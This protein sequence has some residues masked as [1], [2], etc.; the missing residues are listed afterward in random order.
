MATAELSAVK[1]GFGYCLYVPKR[2][3]PA[4]SG[5]SVFE[6]QVTSVAGHPRT[7]SLFASHEQQAGRAYLDLFCLDADHG[8][9]FLVGPI[10]ELDYKGF[11]DAYNRQG[12]VA[13]KDTEM[14]W[15]ERRLSIWLAGQIEIPLNDPR[16]DTYQGRIVLHG[17]LGRNKENG[18]TISVGLPESTVKLSRRRPVTSITPSGTD[19]V[20]GY[21]NSND[22]SRVRLR[23]LEPASREASREG[24]DHQIGFEPAEIEIDGP[25]RCEEMAARIVFNEEA[26][27]RAWKYWAMALSHNERKGHQGDIGEAVACAALEE[28]GYKVLERHT[29][30]SRT[31]KPR[32]RSRELG[33]DILAGRD[34]EYYVAEVKHW[35]VHT[36]TA[37]REAEAELRR[38]GRSLERKRLERRWGVRIT[39]GFA[40]QLE[41]SY[42]SREALLLSKYVNLSHH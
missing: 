17:R 34:G 28:S 40:M 42:K 9:R 4:H 29:V 15:D 3:I 36:R 26:R 23:L 10:R 25:L 19:I 27:H 24:L 21:K 33:R 6:F 7:F 35:T 1:Y 32:H 12:P 30:K 11:A 16:L 20:L 31:F 38:F 39:G 22:D 13:F 18:V 41:W 5:R 8:E 14:R 2:L 37:I